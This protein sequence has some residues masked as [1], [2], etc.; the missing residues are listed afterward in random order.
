MKK[1]V[2]LVVEPFFQKNNIFNENDVIVNRDDCQRPF[3]ELKREWEKIGVELLTYDLADKDSVV[4]FLFINIP[5][6]NDQIKKYAIANKIPLYAII[7]EL[8]LI[9]LN[10]N[11]L[12][13]HGDFNKIFTYQIPIVDNKKYFRLQYSFIFDGIVN[14]D[15]NSRKF[16]TIIA[17]NKYLD[18][19]NELYSERRRIISWFEKHYPE[20]YCC[21]GSGWE[22]RPDFLG[23]L[24]KIKMH[25]YGGVIERKRDILSKYKFS[26]CLENASSE[27][28][29]V[30]EK[31]FDSLFA[32]CVPIY[33]GPDEISEIIP[34]NCF[35]DYRK[36]NNISK[37]Y[38]HMNNFSEDDY[39]NFK[40]SVNKFFLSS[41]KDV[42]TVEYFIKTIIDNIDVM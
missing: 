9:H 40:I 35:I 39:H 41:K 7:N 2:A 12:A 38:Y 36:F 1:Q 34:D 18:N 25:S 28:G 26:I 30:T 33:R 29:W 11:N 5:D 14:N 22:Y 31:I 17:N 19:P 24:F 4:A 6:Y 32:G 3:I 10:N 42:F 16:C 23:R 8:S 37:L 15:F 20:K 21:Y 13:L 27:S